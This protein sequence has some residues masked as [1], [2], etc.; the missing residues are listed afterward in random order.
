MYN[1][2][3]SSGGL[4]GLI[5][6]VNKSIKDGWKPIGG[7]ATDAGYFFQAIVKDENIVNSVMLPVGYGSSSS[8]QSKQAQEHKH[9]KAR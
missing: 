6:M 9:G 2:I 8:G 7:I 1:V 3:Q 4:P 5:E